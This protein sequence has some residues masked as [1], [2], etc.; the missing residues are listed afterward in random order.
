MVK[1]QA[2]TGKYVVAK[3]ESDNGSNGE[4]IFKQFIRD[5]NHVFL[6]PLNGAY[7]LMDMT[8]KNFKIIDCVVQK[9]KKY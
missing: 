5:G 4:A 2:E 8:G 3:I 6:K 1:M 7:P 9:T